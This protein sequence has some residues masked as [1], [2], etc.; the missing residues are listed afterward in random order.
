MQL[1]NETPFEAA[2]NP[3]FRPNGREVAVVVVKGT[4]RLRTDGAAEP[5]LAARQAALVLA[6]EFGPDPAADAP[7][8]ENDFAPTKP[9]CDVIVYARAHAPHGEPT[10]RVQ[11]G[12]RVS[13]CRK[14]FAAVGPRAWAQNVAGSPVASEPVPFTIQEISYDV[15][16]GGTEVD[17]EDPDKV[18][19]FLQNPVG[20][21]Y[22]PVSSLL[23]ERRLP[24]TEE[25][26]SAVSS[27]TADY[28]PMAFGP[29]GRNWHPRYTYAGTYDEDWLTNRIPFLPEDFDERYYQAAPL[30]QQLPYP[31]G[32]DEITLYNL[33]PEGLIRSRLPREGVVVH[34]IKKSGQ[35]RTTPGNLDTIVLDPD[36]DTLQLCW[37]AACDLER[38]PFELREMIVGLKSKQ[39]LG[40]VR[41]RAAGKTYYEGL[42]QLARAENRTRKP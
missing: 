17:P 15:A 38:D 34:F 20:L 14:S 12:V 7:V 6:D 24:L 37:R 28:L 30:D 29:I 13:A 9:R 8:R 3:S 22:C 25:V 18:H 23:A 42:D 31:A 16:F 41:A 32:G 10:R 35:L 36:H 1:V 27:P 39:S 19:T 26:Y 33:S 2:W 21:G 5:V 40:R 11:V 4:Y